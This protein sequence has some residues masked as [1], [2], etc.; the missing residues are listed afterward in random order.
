MADQDTT[1]SAQT[2]GQDPQQADTPA[3]QA[4]T[5]QPADDQALNALQT[6]LEQT[7]VKLNEMANIA[8]RARAD[9]QNYKR[10][11][12]EEKASFVTFAN[13][14]LIGAI[15]PAL[16][17]FDRAMKHDPK[18]AD[19][20]KGVEQTYKQ[21]LDTLEKRGLTPI[22]AAGQKFDPKIH[23]ALLTAPGEKDMVLEE[24]EKGW[25]LGERVIKASRVK[26]GDGTTAS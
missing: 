1:N 3:D 8:K 15:L 24:L 19:W 9:L 26:V 12:E 5:T 4:E 21:M 23:E 7:Q 16:D 18:D 20:A 14:E 25:M 10:Y 6:E 17:N 22:Q 2:S 13:A 11:T